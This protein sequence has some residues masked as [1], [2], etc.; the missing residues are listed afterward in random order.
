MSF[1][2]IPVLGSQDPNQDGTSTSQSQDCSK[3]KH[4]ITPVLI[5]QKRWQPNCESSRFLTSLLF[6]CALPCF[7]GDQ[8]QGVEETTPGHFAWS[9]GSPAP[10]IP[11]YS[12]YYLWPCAS[13]SLRY[14]C[15]HVIT[16]FVSCHA[17]LSALMIR[18]WQHEKTRQNRW[19]I[20]QGLWFKDH[21]QLD[22]LGKSLHEFELQFPHL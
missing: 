10:W 9:S 20:I 17:Y 3:R 19:L 18:N 8:R 13:P 15:H 11:V 14:S 16:I 2:S 22:S 7:Q 6:S 1:S 5:N 21:F 4:Q 12:L